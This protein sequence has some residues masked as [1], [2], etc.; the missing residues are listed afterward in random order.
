MVV[1]IRPPVRQD[2]KFGE[3]SEALQVDK[4]RNL[5]WLLQKEEDGS[6]K[7]RQY[8]FDRVLWK[9]STQNDAWDAA[10][11]SVVKSA[12]EGYTGCVMCYG[13]T[14]AGKSYTLA[15]AKPGSEGIMVQ[16]FNFLFKAAAEE[17]ELKCEIEIAY[18]QIY[19]D[20]ITDL[21]SPK[22]D[23]EI[24]EDPKEGVYV[25]GVRGIGQGSGGDRRVRTRAAATSPLSL[26]AFLR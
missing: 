14:D 8:V 24:R 16:A 23:I 11:V 10:G 25:A 12:M 7:T 20:G 13:Q 6:A 19:L 3:G 26:G 22:N 9:D 15:N 4:E 5:L 2:E 1:R 21:L 18:V 17:R